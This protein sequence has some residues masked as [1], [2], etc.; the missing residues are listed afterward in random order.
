MAGTQGL[1]VV[2]ALV[3]MAGTH[4]LGT[5]AHAK[6]QRQACNAGLAASY[7]TRTP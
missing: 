4:A 6:Q 3:S 2:L 1:V 7:C 5:S